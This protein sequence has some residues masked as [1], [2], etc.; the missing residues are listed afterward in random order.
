MPRS[1][2]VASVNVN[3]IRAAARKGMAEWVEQAA[4]DIITLQ[5]VRGELEHLEEALPGWRVVADASLQKGR[6]GVATAS[7]EECSLSRIE[8]GR[9]SHMHREV[10]GSLVG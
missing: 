5:E 4:P 7:R 1:V 3:G 8:L 9:V 10:R 6:A 2:R